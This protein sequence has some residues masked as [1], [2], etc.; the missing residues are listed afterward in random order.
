[1]LKSFPGLP[2]KVAFRVEAI[3][4]PFE[5][6]DTVSDLFFGNSEDEA[7]K[8]IKDYLKHMKEAGIKYHKPSY[9]KTD[10]WYFSKYPPEISYPKSVNFVDKEKVVENKPVL[11]EERKEVM[12]EDIIQ[13]KE[14]KVHR[15]N[16]SVWMIN[17]QLKD[18]KRVP[19]DKVNDFI[20]KGYEKGGPR[21]K[22]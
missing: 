18:K 9:E 5:G 13:N 19:A 22:V 21:T 20:A 16:G 12:V 8:S 2:G 17:F 1:M 10:T 6:E 15:L 3:Y 7:I 11:I 4:Y 14:E